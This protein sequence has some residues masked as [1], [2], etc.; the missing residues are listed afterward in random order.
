MVVPKKKSRRVR[1]NT[2]SIMFRDKEYWG[3]AA[4]ATQVSALKFANAW[5]K[6]GHSIHFVRLV[7]YGVAVF[8]FPKPR[9][10]GSPSITS[11]GTS[12]GGGNVMPNSE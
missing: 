2:G 5:R 11:T 3:V 8:V 1:L 6:A 9:R 10:T 7:P 12:F 4:V